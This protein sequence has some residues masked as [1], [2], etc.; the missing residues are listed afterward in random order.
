MRDEDINEVLRAQQ[1]A[2]EATQAAKPD[3]DALSEYH[4]ATTVRMAETFRSV[5]PRVEAT[6]PR[7]VRRMMAQLAQAIAAAYP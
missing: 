4:R 1:Q 5:A 7:E 6:Y 3:L 2:D